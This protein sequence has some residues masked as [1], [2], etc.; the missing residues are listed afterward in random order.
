M[1]LPISCVFLV[2]PWPKSIICHSA[3]NR[4][5]VPLSNQSYIHHALRFTVQV[6]LI[7]GHS[8]PRILLAAEFAGR[9]NLS[10]GD[11][12]RSDYVEIGRCESWQTIFLGRY[13][14][15][16]PTHLK[17]ISQIG[18]LPQVGLKIKTYI[19]NHH[20][21]T[22]ISFGIR[23]LIIFPTHLDPSSIQPHKIPQ[24]ELGTSPCPSCTSGYKN[25]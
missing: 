20:L 15:V 17:N 7:I 22:Q 25:M 19:W 1:N 6:K 24:Q 16:E 5:P 13:L 21:D 8:D 4:S 2:L 12:L 3:S 23:S 18:H 11:F 9:W 10:D 14:V